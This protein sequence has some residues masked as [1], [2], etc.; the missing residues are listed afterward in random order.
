ML[1]L[2]RRL[3]ILLAVRDASMS[4]QSGAVEVLDAGD[5]AHRMTDDA[6]TTEAQVLPTGEVL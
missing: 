1:V 6:V 2:Q 3:N 4:L 5:G